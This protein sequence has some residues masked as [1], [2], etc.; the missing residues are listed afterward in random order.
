MLTEVFDFET[1]TVQSN[2][3]I[4]IPTSSITSLGNTENFF[5]Y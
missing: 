5:N 4:P 2:N 3:N 1:E